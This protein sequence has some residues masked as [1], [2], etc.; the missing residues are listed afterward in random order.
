MSKN[1]LL[2]FQ[3]TIDARFV[4]LESD[5]IPDNSVPYYVVSTGVEEG[6]EAS[7]ILRTFEL[8]AAKKVFFEQA[9]VNESPYSNTNQTTVN[10][11]LNSTMTSRFIDDVRGRTTESTSSAPNTRNGLGFPN[12]EDSF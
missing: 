11:F 12:L 8:D 6:S 5:V 9:K 7:A 10:P 3:D 4:L 2:Y 1:R